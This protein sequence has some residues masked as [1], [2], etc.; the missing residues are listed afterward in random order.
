M[1]NYV[2]DIDKLFQDVLKQEKRSRR[3]FFYYIAIPVLLGIT[4]LYYAS[5]TTVENH[6]AKKA[7]YVLNEAKKKEDILTKK[8]E[9]YFDIRSTHSAIGLDSLYSNSILLYFKLTNPNKEKIFEYDNSYWQKYHSERYTL[10]DDSQISM[11]KDSTFITLT[12]INFCKDDSKMKCR[13]LIFEIK[14]DKSYKIY[15]VNAYQ[16]ADIQHLY[17]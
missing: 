15:S 4:I 2:K 7:L 12:K 11:L 3:A 1:K 9:K 16:L 5:K 10:Q 17:K 8:I 6:A 13:D 14:F